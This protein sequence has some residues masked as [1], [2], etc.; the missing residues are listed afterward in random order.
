MSQNKTENTNGNTNTSGVN[1][2][3]KNYAIM[4]L[5]VALMVLG[6]Y[7]MQGGATSDPAVFNGAEKYNFTRITLS[8][9]LILLGLL[10]QVPA[11]MLRFKD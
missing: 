10:I 8:P 5:G 7:L 3:M 2:G 6:Y 4:L 11:I 9:I 1:M